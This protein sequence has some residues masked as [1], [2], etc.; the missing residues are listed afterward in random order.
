[1]KLLLFLLF[2]LPCLA[3]NNAPACSDYW[4][5]ADYTGL[6]QAKDRGKAAQTVISEGTAHDTV[7]AKALTTVGILKDFAGNREDALKHYNMA[8]TLLTDYPA[9]QI[10]VHINAATAHEQLTDYK[11]LLQSANKALAIN[12]TYGNAVKQALI[13]QT[14]ATYY[15]RTDDMA[16]SASYLLKGISL[17]EKVKNPCYIPLLKLNLANTYIQTNNYA[18]AI[19]LFKDYLEN[20]KKAK[21]TKGYTIAVVNYTECLIEL[22]RL[23][24]AFS[25][26]ENSL[27]D[28]IS[29]GDKELEAVLYY[30]IANLENRRG[31]LESSLSYYKKAYTI[32]GGTTSRFSANIFGDYL[33][34]LDKAKRYQEASALM[35][36]FKNSEAY[37]KS[38]TQDRFEYERSAAAIYTKTGNLKEGNRALTEA[39]RLCDSLR[40]VGNGLKEQEVQAHYQTKVLDDK[41]QMLEKKLESENLLI[42]LYVIVSLAVIIIGFMYIRSYRL[43][44]RLNKERYKNTLADKLLAQQQRDYEQEISNSQKAIID[45][46]QREA[47]SMALRIASFYENINTLLDKFNN[48]GSVSEVK[49]ELQQL[50]KEKDYWKQFE[51]R[52]NNLNP[53]F[54]TGLKNRFPKLTKNDIEFCSLVKL[55][56]SNKEIASLLQISHES[57]ITK[58]YRIRKKMELEED[59]DFEKLLS[60]I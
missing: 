17:L 49:K 29:G 8:L 37:R 54:A 26:L 4:L 21:G 12:K 33:D 45:E 14:I 16:Q 7:I 44:H 25:L 1:M 59:A 60:E 39:L 38:T 23:D 15:F 40:Q 27:P 2:T 43:R 56:L 31:K 52:F 51:T 53:D 50:I 19:E 41:N 55:K 28:V 57:V 35:A 5:K 3:Q 30:R 10:Y 9:L 48:Y 32:L 36:S 47:T 20:N 58:K 18:F 11:Q 34:V 24:E 13:Y 42:I 46:K 22:N 6:Q